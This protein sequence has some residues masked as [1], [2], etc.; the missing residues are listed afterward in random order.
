LKYKSNEGVLTRWAIVGTDTAAYGQ[1]NTTSDLTYVTTDSFSTSKGQTAGKELDLS[2][3]VLDS[4]GNK[5]TKTVTK[6]VHDQ[7]AP[8]FSN[9][10]P[11]SSSLPEDK[12]N[13]ITRHPIFQI[14]EVADSISVRF[15]QVGATP[16]DVVTQSVSASKLTTVGSDITVTVNDTLLNLEKYVFQVFIRDL[17]KNVNVTEKDTLT[18]DKSF[19]NPTATLSL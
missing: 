12:I 17:A 5:S 19:Q 10:F 4:V 9:L 3:V 1:T 13:N 18:F 2:V 15:V 8:T 11:A 16:R 6:V 7:V 14:S